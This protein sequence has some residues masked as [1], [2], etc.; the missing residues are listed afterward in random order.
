MRVP[1][2]RALEVL[3]GALERPACSRKEAPMWVFDGEKW[4]EEGGSEQ[5]A[6]KPEQNQMQYDMILPEL[7]VVEVVPTIPR[8]NKIPFPQA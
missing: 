6:S 4:I 8:T 5:Q 2:G 3:E 7:Q 1:H